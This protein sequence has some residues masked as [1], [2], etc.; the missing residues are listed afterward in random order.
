VGN[1]KSWALNDAFL[2]SELET[3]RVSSGDATRL[4][5]GDATRL[6]IKWSSCRSS[7]GGSS[8]S[9]SPN[10]RGVPS[11]RRQTK[12][13]QFARSHCVLLGFKVDSPRALAKG[14]RS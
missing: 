10:S 2:L 3:P 8:A 13:S 11:S 7:G 14:V 9:S 4:L 6:R 1:P 5:N 12:Q